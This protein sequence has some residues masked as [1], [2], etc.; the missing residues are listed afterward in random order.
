[1]ARSQR[2]GARAG[3]GNRKATGSRVPVANGWIASQRQKRDNMTCG[4]QRSS[5]RVRVVRV[6]GALGAQGKALASARPALGEWVGGLRPAAAGVRGLQFVTEEP[7]WRLRPLAATQLYG[8]DDA[9]GRVLANLRYP[10][11]IAAL[12]SDAVVQGCVPQTSEMKGHFGIAKLVVRVLS[13]I[14]YCQRCGGGQCAA[15]P[16]RWVG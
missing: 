16:S 1:M 10:H 9:S 2:K 3:L 11:R 15:N 5:G 12:P 4:R 13:S 14:I 6:R 8:A 7:A